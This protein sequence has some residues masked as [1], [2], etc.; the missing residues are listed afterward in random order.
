MRLERVNE[1]V[2]DAD[3]VMLLVD[4]DQFK[5]ISRSRLAA[6]RSSTTPGGSGAEVAQG[7]LTAVPSAS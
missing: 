4:H 1:A 2:D 7:A 3:I 6:A 5:S